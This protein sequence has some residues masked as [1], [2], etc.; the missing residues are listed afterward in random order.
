MK[1]VS[2]AVSKAGKT[3]ARRMLEKQQP[4]GL[5]CSYMCGDMC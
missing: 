3:I 1:A 4:R 2:K 5:L